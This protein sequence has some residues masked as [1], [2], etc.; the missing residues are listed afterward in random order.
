[1]GRAVADAA[2]DFSG[3]GVA[4]M[5]ERSRAFPGSISPD[6]IPNRLSEF[7]VLL[8]FSSPQSNPVLVACA[9]AGKPM[10]VGT[11]ARTQEQDAELARAVR[12]GNACAVM[13]PNF[14]IGVNALFS[15]ASSAAGLL[16]GYSCEIV[17]AHH[18]QKKDAPSGTAKKLASIV[19]AGPSRVHS[20]RAGDIPGEHELVFAGN[21][22]ILRISH[23][24]LSRKCFASGAV[25][26]ALWVA[27]RSDGKV[28]PF[29]AVI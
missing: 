9:R 17:E 4:L 8:D 22:E 27:G 19:G 10:V 20:I 11:T 3:A 16:S 26:S 21:G 7:D 29:S 1:M 12:D 15:L 23:S 5:A 28:H 25:R 2:A 14:S 18:E 24:A 6:E 13:S